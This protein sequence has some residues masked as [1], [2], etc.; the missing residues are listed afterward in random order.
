MFNLAKADE[1]YAEL[2][3]E[4]PHIDHELV[5]EWRENMPEQFAK[6]M[7]EKK[8]GCHIF[9]AE[10]YEES[11]VHLK[12]AD[13]HGTG[14]KWDVDTIIRLSGIDFSQVKF[15][16]YDYAYIVNMLYA[17]FCTTGLDTTSYIK[18]AKAYLTYDEFGHEADEKAYKHAT[19]H[20]E[21]HD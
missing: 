11:V 9:D 16:E 20:L 7:Y 18:M 8:Y 1:F 14:A 17:K 4:N 3:S 2:E 21:H 13:G 6:K 15:Y 10:M 5:M 19:K 12:W